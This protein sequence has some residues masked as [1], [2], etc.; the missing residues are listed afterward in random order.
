MLAFL[1]KLF[2]ALF[3]ASNLLVF[4]ALAGS[5]ALLLKWR[6]LGVALLSVAMLGLVLVGFGPVG[7]LMMR[8][9]E[10][11]FARPPETM[12]EPTGIIVLGGIIAY[13]SAS[14][15]AIA[16][17]QDGERLNEAVALAYRYPNAKLVFS[18]RSFGE[19]GISEP[20]IAK[21][22]FMS[23]GVDESRIVLEDRSINT[24]ENAR[25]TRDLLMPELGQ[26]WVLVTSASHMPRA[27][28]AF[29][30]ARFPV[31]PYP[32]GYTTSGRPDEYWGIRL[33][34]ST[35]LVRA[36]VALH[37]WLGLVAYRIMGRTGS[38]LPGP[39]SHDD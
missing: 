28:G 18:G 10:D 2:G 26:R 38:L 5:M 22:F 33:E 13:P 27:V 3:Q 35:N 34:V 31:I 25:F 4:L 30:S 20:L 21:R 37:E 6:R 24:A 1:S 36:D 7:V 11:R 39:E 19:S 9:L 12:P 15:D 16:L 17:T 8:P 32:V 23:L 14:R 29:R